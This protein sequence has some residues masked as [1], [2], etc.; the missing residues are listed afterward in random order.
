MTRRLAILAIAASL[1]LAACGK[2]A[3]PTVTT[4][5]LPD[6][7]VAKWLGAM[8][9][10]NPDAVRGMLAPNAKIM[11]PNVASVSGADA[12]IEYYKGTLASE[13]DFEF[14]REAQAMAGGLAVA[15]G[16]YKV[17]NVTTGSDIEQGKWMS[18]WVNLDGS[19][20]VARIMTNTDSAVAAPVV[21]VEEMAE[22]G[23]AG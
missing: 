17:R 18:V 7:V 15:E 6:E 4:D 9:D 12:I 16:T 21:G 11:P 13:L 5:T 14:V 20:K 10:F 19:W 8:N 23:D 3:V 2:P 1:T 22:G